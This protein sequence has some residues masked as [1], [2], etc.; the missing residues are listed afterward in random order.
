[1]FQQVL[2]TNG[3]YDAKSHLAEMIA[4]LGPPPDTLLARS[5]TMSEYKWPRSLMNDTGEVCNNAQEFFNGPF[6]DAEGGLTPISYITIWLADCI[7]DKFRYNALIPFRNLEHTIPFLE[8]KDRAAFLSFV[9]KMLTW[10]P[11]E[12][13]TARELMDHPFLSLGG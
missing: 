13:K 5:K 10:L 3:Q 9:R 8:D 12:R 7:Q 11:E 2:D 1:M 4:L 6:F